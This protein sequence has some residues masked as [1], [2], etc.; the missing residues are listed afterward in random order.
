MVKKYKKI[1]AQAKKEE[2][3]KSE[4][5]AKRI[6]QMPASN[7]G[8]VA[9]RYYAFF[10]DV[11]YNADSERLS[12]RISLNSSYSEHDKHSECKWGGGQPVT[13][14]SEAKESRYSGQ[15]AFGLSLPVEKARG[16]EY[17]ICVD[18]GN[19]DSVK[20]QFGTITVDFEANID[21]A[22]EFKS[23]A[24]MKNEG[25]W[26]VPGERVN[27]IGIVFVGIPKQKKS[28]TTIHP[29]LISPTIDEPYDVELWRHLLNIELA[30][31]WLYNL[32]TGKIYAKVGLVR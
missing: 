20:H 23:A 9:Y 1:E 18:A 4:D 16:D 13:L 19:L 30:E 11:I 28:Y 5:Y 6:A 2:F 26:F 12:A 14:K 25:G 17:G 31:I 8:L 29:V 27:D 21:D 32:K 7:V 10:P 22:K 24:R 3:E 15:N